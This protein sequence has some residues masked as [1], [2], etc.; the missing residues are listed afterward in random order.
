MNTF[1]QDEANSSAI[2]EMHSILDESSITVNDNQQYDSILEN[3]RLELRHRFEGRV[4]VLKTSRGDS[5]AGGSDCSA[6]TT[7]VK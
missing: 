5:A 6:A 4:D 2:S 3:S 1:P 7:L